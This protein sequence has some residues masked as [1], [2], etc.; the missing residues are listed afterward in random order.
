MMPGLFIGLISGTSMDG[1]DAALVQFDDQS[2]LK[3]RA[4]YCHPFPDPIRAELADAIGKPRQ[5]SALDMMRLDARLGEVFAEAAIGLMAQAA[6]KPSDVEAIGSHGQTLYHAAD[7]D[8]RITIQ[9]GNPALIA[10]RAGIDV[11]ADFRAADLAAGGQ[12]APLAPAIHA[13]LL[14]TESEDRAVVNIGGIANLTVLPADPSKPVLGFDTGPGNCLMDDWID[15]C[16]SSRYD[17]DGQWAASGKVQADLLERLLTDHYFGRTPPKS[18]GRE[19]FDLDWLKTR[20]DGSETAEDVQATLCE[21]SARTITDAIASVGG[22]QRVLICGGGV[23]NLDLLQ[24]LATMMQPVPVESTECVGLA[25]DWVESILLAWLARQH[26]L[27]EPGNIPEVTGA[28]GPRILGARYPA[29][30]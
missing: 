24:R 1:V 21:L 29:P 3:L 4:T 7:E 28:A 26:E 17:S 23:H 9:I 8:P 16:K 22:A 11:I 10:E 25:P 2:P 6:V 14:R 15:H 30:I 5:L 20:L 18:T 12:A 27:A 13:T 19:T